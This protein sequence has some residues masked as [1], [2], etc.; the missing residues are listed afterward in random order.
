MH[1]TPL[2]EN[3]TPCSSGATEISTQTGLS[4]ASP[5]KRMPARRHNRAANKKQSKIKQNKTKQNKTKHWYP[6][7]A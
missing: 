4:E 7:L 3:G 6:S 5:N 2:E 1:R